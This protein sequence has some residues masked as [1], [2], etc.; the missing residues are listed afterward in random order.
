[1]SRKRKGQPKKGGRVT[2][3]LTPFERAYLKL[4]KDIRPTPKMIAAAIAEIENS[5]P[6]REAYIADVDA[7]RAER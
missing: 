3:P 6:S 4:P 7:R 1:M 5:T 2:R